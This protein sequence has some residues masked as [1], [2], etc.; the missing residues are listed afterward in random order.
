MNKL[1]TS[2]RRR[3]ITTLSGLGLGSTLLPGVLW[4]KM[5][6]TGTAKITPAMIKDAAVLAGLEF[7]DEETLDMVNSVNLNVARYRTLH[8]VKIPNDVAP[9]FYFSPIVAGMKVE[10]TPPPIRFAKPTK[11]K[12]PSNLEDVAFW[13]VADLAYLLK[14]RA[15][16]SEELT[17]MYLARLHACN[18]KLNCVV[19]FLDDLALAQAKKADAEIAAGNYKGPLHGMPWGAKDIIAVK[20]YKTTWGSGAYQEQVIDQDAAV[21]V[22]LREAGA[23]LIAKLTTGELA[24][25]DVWFGGRTN[26]PW[27]L[28][29]GASGSSAGPASATAAGCVPFAIGTET[30]GSIL[31]PS[32][33]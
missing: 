6:E 25:G 31:G 33:P 4:A 23:V 30:G 2:T 24:G 7:S 32:R 8:S 19:N 27:K 18:A 17:R 10:R 29:Q 16:S 22:M 11:R 21:V 15:V 1:P 9:P 13:S 20:G 3:F 28:D 14:S 26:N 12:R 5:E